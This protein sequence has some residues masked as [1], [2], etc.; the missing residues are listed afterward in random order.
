MTRNIEQYPS[1]S[2]RLVRED[3]SVVN[4][5]DGLNADGSR[6]IRQLGTNVVGFGPVDLTSTDFVKAGGLA[7]TVAGTTGSVAV[8]TSEGTTI[9]IPAALLPVGQQ[10]VVP[11]TKILKSGTT[12]TI[13]WAWWG[14]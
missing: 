10:L 6:N 11:F 12:A 1:R 13:I 8:V 4:E 3:G 9:T 14:K 2:G 5:A 7:I